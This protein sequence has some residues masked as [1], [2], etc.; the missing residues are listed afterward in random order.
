MK[1][2]RDPL[3]RIADALE[4]LAAIAQRQE[5]AKANRALLRYVSR[6]EAEPVEDDTRKAA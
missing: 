2:T 1:H 6:R 3:E 5:R 4:T